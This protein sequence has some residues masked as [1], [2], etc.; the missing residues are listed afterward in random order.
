MFDRIKKETAV[1][2]VKGRLVMS[3]KGRCKRELERERESVCVCV[4]V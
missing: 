4:C 1:T 2:N 3:M